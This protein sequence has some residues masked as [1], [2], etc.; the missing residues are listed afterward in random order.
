V[1]SLILHHCDCAVDPMVDEPPF[2]GRCFQAARRL[3]LHR[4]AALTAM[5]PCDAEIGRRVWYTLLEMEIM[6]SMRCGLS[7]SRDS[8]EDSFDTR[9]PS[10]DD[11]IGGPG[12]G[13]DSSSAISAAAQLRMTRVLRRVFERGS[14]DARSRRR[15]Q[16]P[17]CDLAAEIEQL[18]S[19]I[20]EA[21]ARLAARGLPERGQISSQ[22]LGANPLTHGELYLDNA[23]EATVLNAFNRIRLTMMKYTVSIAFNRTFLDRTP[24]QG[25][26]ARLWGL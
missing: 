23:R 16:Q 14:V 20:D 25:E 21:V 26:A 7:L 10:Y 6:A 15:Q 18:D 24:Q 13:G 8:N 5:A 11:G 2:I 4:E 17:D 1:A 22:L 3:G 9:E 19:F 12:G